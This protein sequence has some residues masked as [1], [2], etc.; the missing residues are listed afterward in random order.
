MSKILAL[1]AG[2]AAFA[3]LATTALADTAPPTTT[4]F[5]ASSVGPLFIAGQTV[6]TTGA[7]SSAFAP[8]STVVFR[9]YAVDTKTSKL[10]VA[11]DAKYFYVT[12][13]NQPNV[14]L[15]YNPSAPG[16][17]ARMPWSGSWTVPATSPAGIVDFKILAKST[18]KRIGSFVQIPVSTSQLTI[19]SS[20]NVPFGSGPGAGASTAPAAKTDIALYVDSVNGTGPVGAAKRPVGCAQTNVFRR[21]EQVVLRIWGFDLKSG[22]TLSTDNIDTATATF[23]GIAPL[24][25][26]YGAHGA[27]GAKVWFWSTPWIVPADYPLGDATVHIALK[28]DAG[29][30]G[31]FDY[32]LTIV[33]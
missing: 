3:A 17:T 26:N 16:A 31:T 11:K 1:V 19:S 18:A 2:L 24:A 15:K 9:A 10:V 8:G 12:I 22:D 13:P 30:V 4:P 27:T 32:A 21:G 6:N 5:P 14:K 29:K 20:G 28:T 23:P 7:M 25:L 33:P